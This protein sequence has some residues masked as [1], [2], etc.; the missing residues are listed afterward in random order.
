HEGHGTTEPCVHGSGLRCSDKGFLPL[1]TA[2]YLD[3]L[4]W[5]AGQIRANRSSA[6][7]STLPPVLQRLQLSREVWLQLVKRFGRLFSVVAGRPCSI[8]ACRSR[9]GTRRFNAPREARELLST[10]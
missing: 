8:E 1:T 5:T 6:D 4:N 9:S 10:A 2:E 3:L 7:S